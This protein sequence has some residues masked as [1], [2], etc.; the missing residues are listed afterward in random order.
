MSNILI[1]RFSAIGDVAMTIPVIYSAAKANP[2]D[3]FTVLTKD[4]LMPLFINRPPNVQ[5]IGVN[6]KSTEKSFFGFLRY[7]F[8]LRR[9]QF[10]MVL[11]LH[12]VIRSRIVDFIF[13]LNGKKV[14]I[15]D[16]LRSKCKQL[17]AMPPKDI[18]A[19]RPV[20]ERYTDVFRAAGFTFENTFISLY[21]NNSVNDSIIKDKNGHRVGIAPFAGH[22]GKIYPTELMEKVVEALSKQDDLTIF[23]FGG[24]GE[25]EMTLK[26]W[27]EKYKN[28]VCIAGR[29]DLMQEL[30][31]I[32]CLDVMLSM[33]SAN[34]HLASLVGTKVISI[35]GATHPYTGFYGYKQP[36]NLAI[37]TNLPC[38]PC[39][40]YGNKRC[41]RGDWACLYKITPEQIICKIQDYLGKT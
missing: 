26:Q 30:E 5:I 13:R 15:I 10:D 25:E 19:L 17:T 35:W 33:D 40:I 28:T 4:F 21:E 11:D 29:Y 32:S 41:Y 23:L 18:E 34:M 8:M 2:N 20:I 7:A 22:R 27:E 38:R 37:Q 1:I 36:A 31:L 24:R 3:S 39:S 6:T 12:R 16:K 14:F 9:Y